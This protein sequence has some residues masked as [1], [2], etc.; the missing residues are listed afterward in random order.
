VSFPNF[1]VI[2]PAAFLGASIL[3]V[4]LVFLLDSLDSGFRSGEQI[5]TLTG[6]PVLAMVPELP[7]RNGGPMP[8]MSASDGPL[9][10]MFDEALGSLYTRLAH[11]AEGPALK[12][13]LFAS[14]LPKEGKTTLAVCMA[15]MRALAGQRAI[16]VETDLRRPAVHTY[17]N[18]KREPGFGD[19]VAGRAQL[20]DVIVQHE[21]TGAFVLPAGRVTGRPAD[22]LASP[23]AT[24]ILDQ[25]SRD[26][27]LVVLDSPPI[28]AVADATML[29]RWAD[30]TVFVVRWGKTTRETVR[31]GLDQ[32]ANLGIDIT[33]VALSMVH[34][35]RHAEYGYGDSAHYYSAVRKYYGKSNT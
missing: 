25:L 20:E 1:L 35:E 17:L 18:M 7:R 34:P 23:N 13:I 15:G 2:L 28:V 12:S 8:M 16:V 29:A 19:V 21:A 9:T 24:A 3:G 33:G 30:V 26:F 32:F 14:S 5:K 31:F 27:D 4:L 6:L 22:L 11:H 10:A